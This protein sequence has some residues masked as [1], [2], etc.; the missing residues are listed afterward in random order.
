MTTE[1]QCQPPGN[2]GDNDDDNDKPGCSTGCIAG[3]IIGGV[4]LLIFMIVIIF[5][6]I[7]V[8]CRRQYINHPKMR[9]RID[10]ITCLHKLC[11]L[12]NKIPRC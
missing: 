7:I 10:S 1:Y 11:E 5:I 2:G 6:V 9:E 8:I 4:V 3:S 12:M